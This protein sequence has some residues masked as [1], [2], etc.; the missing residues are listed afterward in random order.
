[1]KLNRRK[2]DFANNMTFLT[3]ALW[4]GFYPGYFFAFFHWSLIVILSK[5][6]YQ[7]TLNYPAFN[8]DN[9]VYKLAR[10]LINCFVLNYFGITFA[11]LDFNKILF[12]LKNT[13]YMGL[14][15]LY[16]GLAFFAI[17]SEVLI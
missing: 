11:L 13:H 8:Y 12:Y 16:G 3:S 15:L 2:A 17:T 5:K 9:F 6:C 4:H 7:F 10:Y 1:M 14:L